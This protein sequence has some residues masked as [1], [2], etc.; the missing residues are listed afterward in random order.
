MRSIRGYARVKRKL[1]SAQPTG[2]HGDLGPALKE[3]RM[4]SDRELADIGLSRACLTP[5]GLYNCSE[6]RARQ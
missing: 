6:R 1:G 4:F 2:P 3:L 5:E